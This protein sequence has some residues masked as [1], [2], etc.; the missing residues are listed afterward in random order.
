MRIKGE[1]S[2]SLFERFVLRIR[3]GDGCWT[4]TGNIHKDYPCIDHGGR[5]FYAHRLT[6]EW[7]LGRPLGEGLFSCHSCDNPSCVR[8]SHLFE[9]TASQNTLDALSKGRLKSGFALTDKKGSKHHSAKL[10]E[11]RV[12]EMRRAVGVGKSVLFVARRFGVSRQAATAAVY[13]KTWRHVTEPAPPPGPAR[14]VTI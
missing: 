1:G 7:K 14:P 4:W 11:E 12:V 10:T 8:P 9:G 6:L 3:V 5:R 13:G 2:L